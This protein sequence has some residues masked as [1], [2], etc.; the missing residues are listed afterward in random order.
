MWILMVEFTYL[1]ITTKH[2]F[3]CS[4]SR[5]HPTSCAAPL[6]GQSEGAAYPG[7]SM[8]SH[9]EVLPLSCIYKIGG[10]M[11]SFQSSSLMTVSS[12]FNYVLLTVLVPF[13]VFLTEAYFYLEYFLL[14]FSCFQST[15][16]PIFRYILFSITVT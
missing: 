12:Q 11:V 10:L 16:T 3:L 5:F 7:T 15:M 13:A 2:S 4:Y 6:L 1:C 9:C 14:L 8:G